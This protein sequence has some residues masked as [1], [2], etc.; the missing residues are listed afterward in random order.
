MRNNKWLQLT[1]ITAFLFTGIESLSWAE[2]KLSGSIGLR[3][4]YTDNLL[5]TSTDKQDAFITTVN[6]QMTLDYN[7]NLLTLS[8][9]AGVQYHFYSPRIRGDE[10]HFYGNLDSTLSPY[11]DILFLKVSDS[12]SRVMIDQRRQV[13]LDNVS[14]NLTDSNTLKMN[15]YVIYPLS[16][17]LKTKIG[18]TYV[19]QW[20]STSLGDK[21]EDHSFSGSLIKEL[22]P[23][24]SA[25]VMYTYLMHRP[26][27][28]PD[29]NRHD[30]TVGASLQVGTRLS[31]DGSVGEAWYDSKG[32]GNYNSF[33]WN[34]DA[35]Y[36][37]SELL[38][39]SAT[40]SQTFQ[41]SVDVGPFRRRG[42]TGTISYTGKIPVSLNFFSNEDTY[43]EIDRK[44]N[45]TGATIDCSFPITAK[46]TAKAVGGY[47]YFKF[48]PQKEDV[49]RYGY[50]VSLDYAMKITTVTLG[51]TYNRNDSTVN[52]NDYEN[53]IVWLQ[54]RVVLF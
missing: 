38:S 3:E 32:T 54:A 4:A 45:A 44:D 30:G 28:T 6:P 53:N 1:I 26:S 18:Y 21:F 37:I 48:L 52:E 50:G 34:V 23:R 25:Y 8:L 40:Y 39:L 20:Y 14:V 27:L 11:K 15:P 2:Y 47:T 31:V 49:H 12:F 17:T 46:I 19:N 7:R 51:Y 33:L 16:E 5:L 13:A 22:S 43:L 9:L 10:V 24:I 42:G 29:S 35:K 36:A 41:D